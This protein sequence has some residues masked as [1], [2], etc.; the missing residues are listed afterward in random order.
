MR[1]S[2]NSNLVL[3]LGFF[4]GKLGRKCVMPIYKEAADFEMPSDYAGVVYT[5]FDSNEQ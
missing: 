4:I 3:E 1:V 2:E 5:P